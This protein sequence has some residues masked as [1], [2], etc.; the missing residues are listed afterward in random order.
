MKKSYCLEGD[1]ENNP[2]MDLL[3]LLLKCEVLAG[4]P[5]VPKRRLQR[6]R[7]PSFGGH[8]SKTFA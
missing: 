7:A 6:A 5:G 8:R 3:C 2:L 4:A 1:V